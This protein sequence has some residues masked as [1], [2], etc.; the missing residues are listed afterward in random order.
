MLPALES[1]DRH[2][3]HGR[4]GEDN[5]DR[6]EKACRVLNVTKSFVS[7]GSRSAYS[8]DKG[9]DPGWELN[10]AVVMYCSP[11]TSGGSLKNG[12]GTEKFMGREFVQLAAGANLI[13]YHWWV[14]HVKT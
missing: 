4:G 5:V 14:F 6:V 13:Y 12:V 1:L 3:R 7:V 10:W 2:L 9:E 11:G 8:A